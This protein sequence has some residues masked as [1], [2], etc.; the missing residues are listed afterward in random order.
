MGHRVHQLLATLCVASSLALDA[1]GSS[2]LIQ[3][4]LPLNPEPWQ[5]PQQL[6]GLFWIRLPYPMTHRV[7]RTRSRMTRK[8]IF[9]APFYHACGAQSLRLLGC[10]TVGL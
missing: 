6:W 1:L 5:T 7:C 2:N 4:V 8:I 3:W 9:I 10:Y